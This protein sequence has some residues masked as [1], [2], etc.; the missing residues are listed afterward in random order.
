MQIKRRF[1]RVDFSFYFIFL[2]FDLQLVPTCIKC[3]G[4][5]LELLAI[6]SWDLNVNKLYFY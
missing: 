6:E 3:V 5:D 1:L 4:M 2:L